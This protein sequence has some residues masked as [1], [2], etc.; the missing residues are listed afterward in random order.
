MDNEVTLA[1]PAFLNILQSTKSGF[2]GMD[3]FG[4]R[5]YSKE[6]WQTH[7]KKDISKIIDSQ[8]KHM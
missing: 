8:V 2:E 5:R 1:A 6:G 3:A 4:E 7:R